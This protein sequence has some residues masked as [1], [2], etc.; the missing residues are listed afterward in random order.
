MTLTVGSDKGNQATEGYEATKRSS[1]MPGSSPRQVEPAMAIDRPLRIWQ[2]CES[3]P[4]KYGGGAG[5]IAHQISHA[6]AALGHD[7]RVITTESRADLDYAVRTEY[8]DGIRVDR[9]NLRYLVDYDP[10]GWS[11]GLRSWVRHER[12]IA[13]VI[14][15]QLAVS[16][17]D[18]VQYH[19]TRPFGE[20]VPRLIARRGVPIVAMLHE[21]WFICG[22]LFLL[23]SPSSELCT[24]PGP[25]KCS[26]CMYSHYDGGHARA[27]FKLSWRLPRL[28]IFPAY[29]LLR[30][31]AARRHLTA[32]IGY[33]RYSVEVHQRHLPA[34]RYV[35]LGIDLDGLPAS[36]P[37]RPR[38]PLRFGFFGGFQNNKGIWHVLDSA[39]RL[40][41]DGLDFELH[42]WGPPGSD[43]ANELA[44]RG[45]GDRALA[46]GMYERHEMW[47]AYCEVDV[48]VMATTQYENS[49]R[50]VLEARAVGAPTIAPDVGGV[51][52]SIRHDVDGL[53]YKF[54][55]PDD[56][57]RQ[58]RR[59]LTEPG[60]LK[61][62]IGGLQPVI[63]T[64]TRGAALEAVYR[65]IL[66]EVA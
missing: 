51:G 47:D 31:R 36:R 12:A 10:D 3:Y 57:E 24:G 60:L 29:R 44:R 14:E 16:V 30:R 23:R 1:T 63:D 48:A 8:D 56:L 5:I 66:A 25:I 20:A 13:S 37:V 52:E 45:L 6:L 59:I 46:R 39:A 2:V 54:G 53:L 15:E 49:P 50:V 4:P 61:R 41:R 43:H 11:V 28:G 9:V 55:D 35:A 19:T 42:I 34:T 65:S 33:S 64:R 17:P 21:A 62:L 22:R 58:M 27:I 7:V 26:E 40:M 32:A 38:T 18:I